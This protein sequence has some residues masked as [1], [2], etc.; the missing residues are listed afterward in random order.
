MQCQHFGVCGGCTLPGVEYAEQLVQ[1]QARLARLLGMPVP[2][3]LPSPREDRFR[4]KVAF[5][6]GPEGQG[7]GL[8]MGHYARGSKQI[9]RINECPVHSDR[10]NRIAFALRDRLIRARIYGAGAQRNGLVRH[11]IVR[12][13][14]DDRQAVAMLVVTKNDK[15]LRTPIRGLLASPDR[16]DGFF[17]N[18]HDK[19]GP[20]MVGPETIRIDGHSHVKQDGILETSFLVSPTAFFQ[21]NIGVAREIVKLVIEGV[22]SS[23]HILDLYSGSGLFALPLAKAGAR[24]TAVEENRQATKDAEANIRLNR[25]PD[26]RVRLMTS[27]VEDALPRV[28]RDPWD[29]VILDPPRQGC[30]PEVLAAV[31]EGIVP[32][33]AVYVSCNPEALAAELP[34]ILKAGY[35][36][37]RIQAV[38]MFPHTDHIE[39]VVALARG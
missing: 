22:G 4:T 6:F 35:R 19:P 10:G 37:T 15:A 5:V 16:P 34:V 14:E 21:T 30:P 8:V 9:I 39:T 31:F 12:T 17:V 28:G 11:I 38:D 20:Y 36:V 32:A 24:V 29:A 23:P 3:L 1:K 33:R 26:G 27:S 18:I 25:I 7:R 2:P 13:T